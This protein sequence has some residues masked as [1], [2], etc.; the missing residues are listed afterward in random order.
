MAI[1]LALVLRE[2]K[3]GFPTSDVPSYERYELRDGSKRKR[4]APMTGRLMLAFLDRP[5]LWH[6]EIAD[7]LWPDP[8]T[9]PDRFLTTLGV[10]IYKLRRA[11]AAFGIVVEN[12]HGQGYRIHIPD[13]EARRDIAA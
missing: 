2:T 11:V 12:V 13:D 9:M 3:R 4:L 10:R 6:D 8:D 5:F 7:V 1:R